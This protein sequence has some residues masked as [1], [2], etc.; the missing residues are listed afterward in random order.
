MRAP[1]FTRQ[2]GLLWLVCW[3]SCGVCAAC[4]S[5]PA[6]S[7]ER[8]DTAFRAIQRGEARIEA[9]AREVDRIAGTIADDAGAC[10]ERCD[11]FSKAIAEAR[12]GSAAVCESAATIE[13]DNDARV[14]CARASD[15]STAITQ[16]ATDLQAR[17]GCGPSAS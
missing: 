5:S 2:Q 6:P 4:A 10:V 8:I 14:R 12:D 17:C 3:L 11:P 15:R 9:A 1:F 16:R 13:N 7:Q